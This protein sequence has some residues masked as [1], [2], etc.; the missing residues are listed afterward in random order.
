MV[1]C[2]VK[3]RV[4]FT[5]T[6][7]DLAVFQLN[8]QFSQIGAATA[9]GQFPAGANIFPFATAFELSVPR[10]TRGLTTLFLSHV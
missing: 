10:H 6:F 1:C 2:L 5:F 8:N 9:E 7:S 3:Y 4:N